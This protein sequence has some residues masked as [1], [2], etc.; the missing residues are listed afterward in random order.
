MHVGLHSALLIR[1]R[2]AE[3]AK[4]SGGPESAGSAEGPLQVAHCERKRNMPR[5]LSGYETSSV[6]MTR[7]TIHDQPCPMHNTQSMIK[8]QHVIQETR[9]NTM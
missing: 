4:S 6:H 1:R 7:V 5:G 9:N 3:G 2:A 8:A